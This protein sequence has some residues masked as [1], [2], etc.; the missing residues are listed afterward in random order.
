MKNI[1]LKLIALAAI[2]AC[3]TKAMASDF[4]LEALHASDIRVSQTDFRVPAPA[5]VGDDDMIGVSLAIR[6]PFKVVKRGFVLMSE[7]NKDLTIVD[8]NAPVMSKSGEFLK[9]GNIQMDVNGIVVRPTVTLKPYMEGRDKLAIRVQRVQLHAVMEPDVKAV[10]PAMDQEEIMAQVMDSLIKSIHA[11]IDAQLKP[12]H[13]QYAAKEM[14]RMNYDKATWT[15]HMDFSYKVMNQLIPSG[16]VGE[17]HLAAFSFD[18]GALNLSV[19]TG[20]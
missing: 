9:V 11:A 13:G 19:Q 20:D 12:E 17:M 14:L 7:A 18:A 2:L 10:A 8:A 5:P 6:V 16:L 3:G 15:L 4:G 1:T